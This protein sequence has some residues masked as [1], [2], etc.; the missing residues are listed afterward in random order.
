VSYKML[1]HLSQEIGL[2]DAVA[3]LSQSLR[4]ETAMVNFIMG[5]APLL[6]RLMLP[7]L[8]ASSGAG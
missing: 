2:Q 4:E 3:P 7:K 8:Q 1:I 5:N 6:L